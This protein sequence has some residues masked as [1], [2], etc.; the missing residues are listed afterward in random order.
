MCGVLYVFVQVSFDAV[1]ASHIGDVSIAAA[2]ADLSQRI[3][4][5]QGAHDKLAV[6]SRCR[7]VVS[8]EVGARC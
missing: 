1:C 4:A 2:S 6:R 5:L 3:A 7:R 8:V